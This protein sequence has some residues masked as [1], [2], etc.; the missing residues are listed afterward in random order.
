M[1]EW[2]EKAQDLRI[3]RSR[4]IKGTEYMKWRHGG[5]WVWLWWREM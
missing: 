1:E 2:F 3:E 4:Y 5:S